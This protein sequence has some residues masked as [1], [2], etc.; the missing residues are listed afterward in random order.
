MLE[1]HLMDTQE[2]W[3]ANFKAVVAAEIEAAGGK[4]AD[5]YRAVESRTGLGYDYVYQIFTRPILIVIRV[6]S[7]EIVIECYRIFDT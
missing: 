4:E 1:S 3:L 7:R 6:P 5:G 2:N